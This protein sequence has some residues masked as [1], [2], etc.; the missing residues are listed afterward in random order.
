[1]RKKGERGENEKR[2]EM[3][4]YNKHEA[5]KRIKKCKV[6]YRALVRYPQTTQLPCKIKGCIHKKRNGRC[7]LHECRLELDEKDDLTG[8]CLCFRKRK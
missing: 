8:I 7:G 5:H 4:S 1:M 3:F 2:S 6:Y